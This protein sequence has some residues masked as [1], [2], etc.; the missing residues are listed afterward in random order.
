[1]K[2]TTPRR[3]FFWPE[4]LP[5]LLRAA[6]GRYVGRGRPLVGVL[7]VADL[8]IGE[9]LALELRDVNLARGELVIRRSKTEAGERVVV[10]PPALVMDLVEWKTRTR[11]SAP[12]DLVLGTSQGKHD[13]RSKGDAAAPTPGR[14]EGEHRARQG[15]HLHDRGAHLA[16]PP[17]QRADPLGGDRRD[18]FRDSRAARAPNPT[19]T[20]GIYMVATKHRARLSQAERAAFD[21]AIEW[22]SLG[23]SAQTP[24]PALV[25][26]PEASAA[27][28]A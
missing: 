3:T 17:A 23:T 5:A 6:E 22:A 10:L 19:I 9:A 13:G 27:Q 16:R 24:D 28:A 8:R 21:E 12:T 20:T 25:A 2:G 18:R 11:F 4:Q 26:V 14:R 15:R 7:A 1:V